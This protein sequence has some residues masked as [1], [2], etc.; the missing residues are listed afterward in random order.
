MNPCYLVLSTSLKLL[1]ANHLKI[2]PAPRILV[3]S[4]PTFPMM[5]Y[6][7]VIFTWLSSQQKI[8]KRQKGCQAKPGTGMALLSLLYRVVSHQGFLCLPSIIEV[9][10][11]GCCNHPTG[12]HLQRSALRPAVACVAA[13]SGKAKPQ[14]NQSK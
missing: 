9:C 1:C 11:L 4:P 8:Y 12:Q 14:S 6:A 10:S 2:F 13:S 3:P 7:K 5:R